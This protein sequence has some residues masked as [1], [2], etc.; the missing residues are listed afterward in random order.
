MK[1]G[2][3][4]QVQENV[5]L[6]LYLSSSIF[7]FLSGDIRGD[8]LLLF[9]SSSFFYLMS[10]HSYPLQLPIHDQQNYTK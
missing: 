10:L 3:D 2:F 5:F 4:N 7:F 9:F 8:F 6:F 1:R